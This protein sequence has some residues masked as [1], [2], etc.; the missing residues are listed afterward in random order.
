GSI[1]SNDLVAPIRGAMIQKLGQLPAD[2]DVKV[3]LFNDRAD[4]RVQYSGINAQTLGEF[5]IWFD[6]NF[7]PQRDTRL[8]DTVGEALNEI[9][10]LRSAYRRV[11]LTILSDGI[12]DPPVS[13]RYRSWKDLEPLA[14]N[15]KQSEPP[16]FGT[17]YT[18][19]FMPGE[20]PDP[21][22]LATE[23]VPTGKPLLISTH[24]QLATV[25]F[26]ASKRSGSVPL[27]V[28][29]RDQTE[30]EVVAYDWDFGDG[31]S[32][33][34]RHPVHVYE[35]IGEYRPRL[36]VRNK[37]GIE[38]KCTGVLLIN[39]KPVPP[40]RWCLWLGLGIA[41]LFLIWVAIVVPFILRPG[42]T[43]QKGAEIRGHRTYKLTHLC[44]KHNFRWI[45][46]RGFLAIGGR[47]GDGLRISA[48]E[49][50]GKSVARIHRVFG[51]DAY[52]MVIL[53]DGLV[54]KVRFEHAPDGTEVREL[55]PI[56]NKTSVPLRDGNKFEIAGEEY[57]WVQ[58]KRSRRQQRNS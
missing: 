15:L 53:R 33:D 6:A 20:V 9:Q 19:G 29:F 23:E 26:T 49:I 31:G 1:K 10:Q 41:A 8:Y 57:S 11:E 18:L 42:M 34:E 3:V 28:Q 14:S 22:L 13:T 35:K 12:E 27:A 54:S 40:S 44:R 36:T 17:W 43:P 4:R 30:G 56:S 46:P 48:P 51:T 52:R 38:S 55:Q 37:S 50:R 7:V 16:F 47:P 39:V 32:S 58:R 21:S 24:P 45:W 2:T 25:K 5:S